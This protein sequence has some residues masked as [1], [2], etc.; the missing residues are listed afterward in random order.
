MGKGI[1]I[2]LH[3]IAGENHPISAAAARSTQGKEQ[4]AGRR[5]EGQEQAEGGV[6]RQVM[7]VMA[8]VRLFLL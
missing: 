6:G 1:G 8:V 7:A 5:R 3:G 2:L 4:P